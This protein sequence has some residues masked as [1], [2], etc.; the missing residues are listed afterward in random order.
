MQNFWF[1]QLIALIWTFSTVD[2]FFNP[3]SFCICYYFAED[4]QNTWYSVTKFQIF[5]LNCNQ[6]M[7]K[8]ENYHLR[9]SVRNCPSLHEHRLIFWKWRVL[10]HKSKNFCKSE[11]FSRKESS[12]LAILFKGIS[13]YRLILGTETTLKFKPWSYYYY[14]Y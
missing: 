12:N 5:R 11:N 10:F 1:S 8:S 9:S 3:I 13:Y 6:F 14:Y 4:W 7:V 2:N